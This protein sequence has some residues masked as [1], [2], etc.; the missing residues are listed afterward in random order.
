MRKK[1]REGFWRGFTYAFNGISY[2]LKH[3][4]NMKI[5]FAFTVLVIIAGALFNISKTEWIATLIC[6]SAVICAEMANSAIE[7]LSDR[8]TTEHD[9]TIKRAKDISAGM[10]LIAATIS[11]TIG[12]IIF[13]PYLIKLISPCL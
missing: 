11:A 12:V 10:V 7:L 1:F 9:E 2:A 6:I 13:L 5:H 8:I 4:R 3:E